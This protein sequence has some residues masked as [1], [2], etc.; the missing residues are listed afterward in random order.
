MDFAKKQLLKYGW[1]EG[2]GI[3]KEGNQGMANALKPKYKLGKDGLGYD[4]SKELVDTWWTR[5]YQDS[6][7]RININSST[8]ASAT[9][10]QCVD[11]EDDEGVRVTFTQDD[12]G[13]DEMSKMRRRM[14]RSNFQE[15]SKGAVLDNG[16]MM[17][18]DNTNSET[19]SGIATPSSST[20]SN[21][22][23]DEDLFKA[24][25]GR[26]AHKAARFGHKLS[27]KLARIAAQEQAELEAFQRRSQSSSTSM[28][29]TKDVQIV[30][31][32]RS[33]RSLEQNVMEEDGSSAI[34]KE[35][36]RKKKSSLVEVE[37]ISAS[38]NSIVEEM[39]HE[40]SFEDREEKRRKRKKKSKIA[41]DSC[42]FE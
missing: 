18:D 41:A 16:M 26:T 20:S 30:K 23:S 1:K 35:K 31:K 21:L 22:L 4:M 7:S 25:G 15:F 10:S 6:L 17:E 9:S 39:D 3:G 34:G 29:I 32:R 40:P 28:N 36:K 19:D 5:S 11:E 37:K 2:E 42:D 13:V 24:C 33:K 27:G 14:M 8:S 38:P 12:S